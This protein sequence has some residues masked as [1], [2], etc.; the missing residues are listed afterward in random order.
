MNECDLGMPTESRLNAD[1]SALIEPYADT[2]LNPQPLHPMPR[3]STA[4]PLTRHVGQTNYPQPERLTG[5]VVV[6]ALAASI[7]SDLASACG[8]RVADAAGE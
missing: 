7:A 5:L 8:E 1:D 3:L 6:A 2:T 4:C